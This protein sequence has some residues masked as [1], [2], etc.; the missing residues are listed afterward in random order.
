MQ[1]AGRHNGP[2]GTVM[3]QQATP[4]NTIQP[5]L[6]LSLF[7]YCL[8][9]LLNTGVFQSLCILHS[10]IFPEHTYSFKP[11]RSGGYYMYHIRFNIKTFYVMSARCNYA[12][13]VWISE[14]TAITS[15]YTINW[16]SFYKPVFTV[17]Y[18]LDLKYYSR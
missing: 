18:E 17:R 14:Q 3:W 12:C 11:L 8:A 9:W 10:V 4:S 6:A 13:S 1:T 5:T 16:C 2:R 7:K 15:L